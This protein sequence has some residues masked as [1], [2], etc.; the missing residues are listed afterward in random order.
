MRIQL[1]EWRS[2]GA[3]AEMFCVGR[4]AGEGSAPVLGGELFL[5][6]RPLVG[7]VRATEALARAVRRFGPDVVYLRY[8]ALVPPPAALMR[9]IPT[10]VEIN[11]NDVT[12][13]RLRGR[14]L[15]VYNALNRRLILGS[16]AGLVFVTPELAGSPSFTGFRKPST[17]ISN[18]VDLEAGSPLAPA[19]N[20]R[21][22]LAYMAGGTPAPWN[23]VDKLVALARA[24]PEFDFAIAGVA[25]PGAPGN[26]EVHP[27]LARPAYEAL[28]ARSD[29][30]VGPLA[31]HRKRME[32]AVP[33]RVR[34]YLLYG[35][36]VIIAHDD[37]DLRDS[38]WFV[39]RLP[40]VESNVRE[41]VEEIRTFVAS[42]AEKRVPRELVAPRIGAREKEEERLEFLARVCGTARDG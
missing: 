14:S 30:G 19:R 16:A 33:L 9:R 29:V 35:L 17:V 12:E 3:E 13:Y 37:P 10:V 41:H 34:E 20:Q 36:P 1:A 22:R 2:L 28:L 40:N 23:G 27:L 21:P 25:A 42:V 15:V 8:S 26:V 5:Y 24:L 18:G 38:P 4:D 11:T 7:R 39:L 31:L 32:E 6:R